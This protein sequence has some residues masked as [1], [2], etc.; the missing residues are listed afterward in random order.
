M[1]HYTIDEKNE[2]LETPFRYIHRKVDILLTL[3]RLLMTCGADTKRIT[4]EMIKSAAF[5]GI[6]ESYLSINI[7]YTTIMINIRHEETNITSFVKVID[8][9]PNMAVVGA[10]SALTWRALERHFSLTTYERLLKTLLHAVRHYPLWTVGFCSALGCSGLA[11]VFG[12]DWFDSVLTFFCALFGFIMRV[13]C[14]RLGFNNYVG[15]SVCAFSAMTLA[16]LSY[17]ASNVQSL[18]YALVCCTLFMI[19]GVPLIN[20]VIDIINTNIVSGITRGIRTILVV[21]SMTLGMAMA[22]YVSP[23]PEFSYID[24][25]PHLITINQIVGAFISAASFSILFNVPYRLVAYVGLGGIIC[26]GVRNLLMV[27][28]GFSLPGATFL[29]SATMSVFFLWLSNRLRASGPVLILPSAISLMPGVL[30]Y[31]FLF[32]I[33]HISRLDEAGML[34]AAQNGVTAVLSIIG[35]AVG[36][37]IPNVLA[38][39]L[40]DKQKQARLDKLLASRHAHEQ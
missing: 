10:V 6:P 18:M 36:V 2:V 31:R 27:H 25:K 13:L 17:D 28:A 40:I 19:P 24:I 15:I 26:V 30:L 12:G 39:R 34:H 3:G 16:Y 38:Q 14:N 32:D 5:L 9:L 35:I 11:L 23:V 33:L 22:L 8:H 29:G 37:A 21:G 20:S 7:N 4:D 1:K